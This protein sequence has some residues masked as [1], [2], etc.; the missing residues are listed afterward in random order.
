MR[1]ILLIL[2]SCFM[3]S[4]FPAKYPKETLTMNKTQFFNWATQYNNQAKRAWFS[5][6]NKESKY[7][8]GSKEITTINSSG[9]LTRSIISIGSKRK[10]ISN[11]RT[12]EQIVPYRY[13]NPNYIHPG[14]LTIINPYVSP[15]TLKK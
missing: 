3:G 15:K 6:Y 8:Y 9:N 13:N 14:P 5:N 12:Q 11:T 1:V 10:Q 2:V 4:D 7:Y